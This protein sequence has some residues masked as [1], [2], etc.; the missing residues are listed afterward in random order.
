MLHPLTIAPARS[1]HD[2]AA[3]AELFAAYAASLDIDLAFQDFATELSTIPGKY[4]APKGEL[5]LAFL[6]CGTPVGCVGLRPFSS[7]GTCEMKRLFVVPAGR[8]LGVG[9]A[10]VR[11]II[12]CAS[13]AGYSRMLLDT[14]ASMTEAATLYR[15][16]GFQPIEP[17]Y[18]NPIPGA[19]FLELRLPAMA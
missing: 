10:L 1:A 16:F 5:L 6:A 8:G 7:L 17:Y 14:L 12:K 13:A 18:A 11:E 4:A 15:Q 19:I 9:K 3:T 2:L